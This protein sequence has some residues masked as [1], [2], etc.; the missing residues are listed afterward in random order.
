MNCVIILLLPS[1]SV[2]PLPQFELF[3]F[4][5]LVT[6]AA[7]ADEYNFATAISPFVA[8]QNRFGPYQLVP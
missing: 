6:A 2:L 4:S 7:D 1:I 8:F 3:L 5:S